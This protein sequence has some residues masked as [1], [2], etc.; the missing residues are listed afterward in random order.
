MPR[1]SLSWPPTAFWWE[2][3]VGESSSRGR[4]LIALAIVAW[5]A[6]AWYPNSAEKRGM[7]SR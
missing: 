5:F 7:V 4:S 3:I 2:S 6:G 1:R